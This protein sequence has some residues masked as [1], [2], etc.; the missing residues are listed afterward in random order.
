MT[1]NIDAATQTD[2]REGTG[3]PSS[4]EHVPILRVRVFGGF[5]VTLDGSP[6]DSVYSRQRRIQALMSILALNLG[7]ELFCDYL[8]DSIW[9]RSTIDKKR[10]SFY[11]LW[12]LTTRSVYGGKRDENPYFERRQGTCRML[13][14]HVHTDVQDVERACVDLMQHD[15]APYDALEAYR[16]LQEAYRGDL[17]PGEMEN[18]IIIRARRDWRERVSGA[19]S[20]AAQNMMKR[21]EDRVALWMATA[22]CRLS[23]MREDVV[24]LRMEL[25]AKM[26]MQAY[27]VRTFN[28]LEDYLHDEVGMAPSPQ[29]VQLIQQVV[30]ASDLNFA[31]AAQ[32]PPSR[33]RGARNQVPAKPARREPKRQEKA[34]FACGDALP[35]QAGYYQRPM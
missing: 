3:R 29:S 5:D 17:L 9:P 11:N 25:L 24:R 18:A 2:G 10:H 20:S 19:L 30:D 34:E 16:R 31:L 8:A 21:G 6:L 32:A 1:G 4:G 13:G 7:Q 22:A 15:L 35:V 26:G 27:A 23:G 33:R 14:A 12:Y 28:E